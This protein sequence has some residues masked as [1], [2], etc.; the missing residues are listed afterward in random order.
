MLE[1]DEIHT[2]TILKSII[3]LTPPKTGSIRF[4]GEDITDKQ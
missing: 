1:V 2:T 3:G 4:K